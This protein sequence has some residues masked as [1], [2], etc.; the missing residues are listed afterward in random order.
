MASINGILRINDQ[1][2][3]VIDSFTSS[4]NSNNLSKYPFSPFLNGFVNNL[5]REDDLYGGAIG[6]P[7]GNTTIGNLRFGV[8]DNYLNRTE[9]YRGLD[10]GFTN[11]NGVLNLEL[12]IIGTDVISFKIRFDISRNQYPTDYTWYDIDNVEH[13]VTG[14]TSN[15]ITFQQR[16]GYG[17]TRIVFS[18]W[19]LANTSVGITFIESVEL[20]LYLDKL[21]IMDFESQTQEKSDVRNI[22]YGALANTGSI[23]LKDVDNRILENAKMGYLNTYIFTLDLYMNNK[24]FV[25][26][27]TNQ[28]PYYDGDKTI[29][30][31]LTN[32]IDKWNQVQIPSLIFQNTNLYDVF[33]TIMMTYD[34]ELTSNEID[35]M[36]RNYIDYMQRNGYTTYDSIKSYMQDI[37]INAFTLKADSMANQIKKICTVAQLCCYVDDNGLI[38]FDTAR[39]KD[40]R[41]SEYTSLRI[42]KAEEVS[43]LDYDILVSNRYDD[44]EFS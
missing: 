9:S 31:Q 20:D 25:K 32:E 35:I 14:N 26:H 18:Q 16:A 44:V 21:Q 27:I 2:N 42:T 17:T 15:E 41:Q 4:I 29:K 28:S 43:N 37:N 40:S 12:T 10:Y 23:E 6:T 24:L 33:V 8:V 36:L 39:P 7:I 3:G 22:Q 11:S 1:G 19:A 34:S 13:V 30:L 38:T 5:T